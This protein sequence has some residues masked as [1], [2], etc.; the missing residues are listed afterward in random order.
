MTIQRPFWKKRP[1][2]REAGVSREPGQI[3]SEDI[4]AGADARVTID[5]ARLSVVFCYNDLHIVN[6]P[7]LCGA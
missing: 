1:E 7:R 2:N 5:M 3:I 4:G 6:N